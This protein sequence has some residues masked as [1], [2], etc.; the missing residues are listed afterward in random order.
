[1]TLSLPG[2]SEGEAA[3]ERL[4]REGRL[5]FVLAVVA[6][7]V[8][9]LN[10]EHGYA[11]GDR[12]LE[13]LAFRLMGPRGGARELFRWSATAFVIVS[14]SL[15]KVADHAGME[16]VSTALFGAWP[17]EP[18]SALFDRIDEYIAARL[19]FSDAA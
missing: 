2:R 6:T 17:N 1:M 16:G 10:E 14:R 12:A 8:P 3:I 7:E 15:R 18:A 13:A 9:Q 4:I 19:A 11:A 5:G